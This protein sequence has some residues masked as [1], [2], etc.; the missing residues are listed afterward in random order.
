MGE[1]LAK[2]IALAAPEGIRRPFLSLAGGRLGQLDQLAVELVPVHREQLRL[3]GNQRHLLIRIDR[4]DLA[5]EGAPEH[6]I[7]REL[8]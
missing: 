7:A 4:R 3:V 5:V 1:M 6:E 8:P 2:A